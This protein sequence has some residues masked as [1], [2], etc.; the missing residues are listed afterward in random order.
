MRTHIYSR[1]GWS[2]WNTSVHNFSTVHSVY[3]KD[4]FGEYIEASRKRGMR[5]GLFYSSWKNFY[6]GVTHGVPGGAPAY[7]KRPDGGGQRR[8]YGG[9]NVTQEWYNW[10]VRTQV[11][12]LLTNY[13]DDAVFD[14]WWDTPI[15][16]NLSFPP[17]PLMK[18]EFVELAGNHTLCLACFNFTGFNNNL[19]WVGNEG[20]IPSFLPMW[21]A[22][23]LPGYKGGAPGPRNNWG[24]PY[25]EVYSPASCDDVMSSEAHFWM[26]NKKV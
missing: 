6:L 21:H 19:R 15:S 14:W 26:W 18:K 10:M 8:M 25:G 23:K 13:G 3:G 11:K 16:R 24:D 1:S 4:V 2:L 22:M 17:V 9:P 20:G 5:A 12:E 7:P